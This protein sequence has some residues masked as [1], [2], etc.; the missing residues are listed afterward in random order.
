[1]ARPLKR[2]HITHFLGLGLAGEAS[3]VP[4]RDQ[5]QEAAAFFSD[6]R[7]LWA[8]AGK[9]TN[10]GIGYVDQGYGA[11]AGGGTIGADFRILAV[12]LK[13]DG[14]RQLC[15]IADGKFWTQDAATAEWTMR[16][17]GLTAADTWTAASY[18]DRLFLASSSGVLRVWDAQNGKE[19]FKFDPPNAA[20]TNRTQASAQ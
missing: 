10:D 11:I 5:G 13:A 16:A 17:S 7:N 9:L 19:L 8:P 6:C 18:F 3:S 12:L 1:M 14:T 20:E 4:V 2:V 15:G